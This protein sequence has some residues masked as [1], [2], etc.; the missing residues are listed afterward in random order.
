MF[1]HT[2]RSGENTINMVTTQGNHARLDYITINYPRLLTVAERPYSFSPQTDMTTTLQADG[3]GEFTQVWR[4][5][6]VGSP[7][8]ALTL[9]QQTDGKGLFTTDTPQRRFVIFNTNRDF[10]Q[11]EFVGNVAN[12]NLHADHDIDYVIAANR[13]ETHRASRAIGRNSSPTRFNR[14][15]GSGQPSSTM[16]SHRH[17]RMSNALRRYLKMLYDRAATPKQSTALSPLDGKKPLDNRF[18]TEEWKRLSV[19]DYLL[20]Y[21]YDA[22][23]QSIGTVSSFVTDDFYAL[24]DDG[25]GK[26]IYSEKVDLSTG[27]MVCTTEEE[28]KTLVDKVERYLKNEDAGPWKNRIVMMADDGDSNEHAEDAETRLQRYRARRKK[29]A[30]PSTKSTGIITI[31][32]REQRV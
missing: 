25:E 21:E 22:S 23:T 29:N 20:A 6:Q 18:V 9:T 31:A 28:A 12:Q 14:Q 26:Y 4:I 16:S 32:C 5:G 7:T 19:D 30:S 11:P 13:W 15:S 17:S 27:R 10:P 2:I 1:E 3:V 8:A 24:L